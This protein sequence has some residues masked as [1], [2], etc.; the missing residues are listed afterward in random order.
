MDAATR[1]A[2]DLGM[3]RQEFAEQNGE[4]DAVLEESWRRTWWQV[5]IADAFFAAM[6]RANTFPTC[7]VDVTVALPCEEEEYEAGVSF[8]PPIIL[9]D[10]AVPQM[11]S[12][13]LT[14][15]PNFR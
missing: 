6:A 13:P 9:N 4:G 7:N 5:Y 12:Y 3:H 15:P 2:L 14:N 1:L 8:Q 10:F 11:N